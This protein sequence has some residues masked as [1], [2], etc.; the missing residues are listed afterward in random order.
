MLR[1]GNFVATAAIWCLK[2]CT[3]ALRTAVPPTP[4]TARVPHCCSARKRCL[5]VTSTSPPSETAQPRR[6]KY[7]KKTHTPWGKHADRGGKTCRPWGRNIHE[8]WGKDTHRG[9]NT[10]SAEETRK[11]WDKDAHVDEALPG[12]RPGRAGMGSGGMGGSRGA[13]TAEKLWG[14][15]SS[16]RYLQ[17]SSMSSSWWPRRSM[18]SALMPS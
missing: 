11:P 9:K 6:A 1:N 7:G 14:P 5:F 3:S 4:F 10:Q 17:E 8:E 15:Q 13:L 16:P 12:Q 2:R 18:K